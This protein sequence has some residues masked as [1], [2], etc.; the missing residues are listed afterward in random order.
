MPDITMC[1]GLDCPLKKKCHRF[2][3]TPTP[4]RQSY[5]IKPPYKAPLVVHHSKGTTNELGGC[6]YYSYN[7]EIK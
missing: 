5:F 6:D 3:A 1:Q 2:T 4:E 7:V